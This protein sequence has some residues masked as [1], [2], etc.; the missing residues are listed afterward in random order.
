M[1]YISA[2]IATL[3]TSIFYILIALAALMIMITIHEAGHYTVGKLFKF[4]IKEFAIGFGKPLYKK[5]RKSGEIFSIRILPLGGFCAFYGEDEEN[6]EEGAFN[7]K[8]CYQRILVLLAGVVFN[9]V[10]AML[11]LGIFFTAY[12][13]NL[14]TVATVYTN[15]ENVQVFQEG[16]VIYEINGKKVYTFAISNLS[17]LIGEGDAAEFVVI[18][19]GEKVTLSAVKSTY[20][21]ENADGS[22]TT[23]TG[24]GINTGLTP[25]KFGFFQSMWRGILFSFQLIGFIF[26]TIGQLLTGALGIKG[27]IGGPIT[28][29]SIMS[30]TVQE[31]GLQAFINLLGVMSASIAFMNIL[32]LPALDGSRIVFVLIEW[33]RGKPINR[34]VEGYIHFIGF[35]A[36]ITLTILLDVI[37]FG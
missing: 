36:L 19:D 10:S 29:I 4:K 24:Y 7:T 6:A 26:E 14:P 12:G 20:N 32:P 35:I 1:S 3:S 27:S 9:F 16:D 30:S 17:K 22:F 23:T 5:V 18:R 31:Y 25:Y 8:P 15:S 11:I 21:Y 34:R 33:I 13:Y 2:S 37:N 28:T